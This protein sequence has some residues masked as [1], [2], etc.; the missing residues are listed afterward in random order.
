MLAKVIKTKGFAS[1]KIIRTFYDDAGRRYDVYEM[2][3]FINAF[4]FR[5]IMEDNN[6]KLHASYIRWSY[7]QNNNEIIR[8]FE[9]LV[10]C[11]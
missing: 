2:D 5:V 6:G 3:N 8:H 9:T 7:Q 4:Y 10:T 1:P 11:V